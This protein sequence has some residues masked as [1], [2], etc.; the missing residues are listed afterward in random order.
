ML[1][2]LRSTLRTRAL[3]LEELRRRP[4]PLTL[5]RYAEEGESVEAAL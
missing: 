4:P 1:G 5:P 2:V 3:A